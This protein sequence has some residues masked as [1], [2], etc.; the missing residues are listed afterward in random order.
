M[1]VLSIKRT[2]RIIAFALVVG[3]LM[4]SILGI[5]AY[6]ATNPHGVGQ[7]RTDT[8]NINDFSTN[9]WDRFR[10]NYQFN[11][12]PDTGTTFGKPTETNTPGS[13]PLQENVRR[14]KDT[15]FIPPSYGVFSGEIPTNPSSMLHTANSTSSAS[16][17]TN[18]GTASANFFN[19]SAGIL[20]STSL[21]QTS[22]A[23]STGNVTISQTPI[24]SVV[25]QSAHFD[26]GSIGF[27]SIPAINTFV[28]VY[29]GEIM[30]D[31]RMGAAHMEFTSVWDGNVG[32]AGHNRGAADYFKGVKNLRIG[33]TITYETTHGVRTY[34]VFLKEIIN[35]TDFSH[36]GW[37]RD[38]IISLI[39][40]VID[41]PDKRWIVQAR[42]I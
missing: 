15:A 42:E 10:F 21:M 7:G 35:E 41:T 31:M 6:A 28:K 16:N 17:T 40:C 34:Q 39:T 3:I 9:N 26:D 11:S 14:N 8:R 30:A 2:K 36:L 25:T 20:Q 5:P 37:T 23:G 19:D 22:S 27:L 24:N 29:A 33:D 4:S 12:G 18:T 38:N 13:N 1:E 32:L